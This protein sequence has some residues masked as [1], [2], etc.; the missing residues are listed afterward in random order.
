M[1]RRC[2]S[3]RWRWCD[4]VPLKPLCCVIATSLWIGIARPSRRPLRGLLRMRIFL[5]AINNLPH[6]E[7][8]PQGASRRTHDVGAILSEIVFLDFFTHSFASMTTYGLDGRFDETRRPSQ[9]GLAVEDV[10]AA[11]DN[12]GGPEQDVAVGHF[13]PDQEPERHAEDE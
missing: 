10:E 5:N 9:L 3:E 7:E 13:I 12:D 11:G 4:L 6:P 8:R 2:F 1:R